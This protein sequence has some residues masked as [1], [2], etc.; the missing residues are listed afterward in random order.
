MVAN[1]V[2]KLVPG[3]R[4][5]YGVVLGVPVAAPGAGLLDKA[6]DD[7]RNAD[8]GAGIVVFVSRCQILL[9]TVMR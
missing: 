4:V 5:G 8:G 3:L 2:G 6:S 7:C 9:Q 1:G